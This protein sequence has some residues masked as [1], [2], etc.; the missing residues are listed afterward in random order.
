VNFV[1]REENLWAVA[2]YMPGSLGELDSIGLSGSEIRFHGKTLLA[3]VAQAQ[4][5]PEEA[6]PEPLLNLLDMP[7]Y[8]RAFK[9]IKA[10][11]QEVSVAKGVSAELLASRR[12]INQLLNWHWNIKPFATL[13][14]LIS[15]WRGELMASSL[16]ALLLEFP[17]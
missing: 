11:V 5:L 17:R 16:Q 3:M 14:E 6:L 1:V 2:R 15:G 9:A 10:L 13:P 4:A 7:G 8:R 12:Q